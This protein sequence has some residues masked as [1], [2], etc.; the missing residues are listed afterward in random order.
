MIDPDDLVGQKVWFPVEWE[1]AEVDSILTGSDNEVIAYI[2]RRD[3]GQLVAI[4]VQMRE[5]EGYDGELH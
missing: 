5:I 1:Q 2:L 4:D 3:N